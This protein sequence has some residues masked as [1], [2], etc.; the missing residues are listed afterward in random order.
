[1]VGLAV[2]GFNVGFAEGFDVNFGVE[3]SRVGFAEG[4]DVETALE[5]ETDEILATPIK[6]D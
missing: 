2:T 5:D 4:C 3:G 1:L 6:L